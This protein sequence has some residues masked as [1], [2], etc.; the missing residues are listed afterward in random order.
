MLGW[1]NVNLRDENDEVP[2]FSIR[3]LDCNIRGN[4]VTKQTIGQ[5]LAF[6]RDVTAPNNVVSYRINEILTDQITRSR[7]SLLSDGTIE[8]NAIFDRQNQS[9]Y[10]IIITAS[11]NATAWGS[12]TSNSED[13]QLNINIVDNSDLSP[14]KHQT[15]NM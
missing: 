9:T 15:T 6:D 8:T 7:F 12:T 3:S 1:V 10:R 14:G 5:F 13:F 11:D 4:L 2:R